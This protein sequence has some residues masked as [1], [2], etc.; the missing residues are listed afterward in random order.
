MRNLLNSKV[1][2][3]IGV[4]VI[5]VLSAGAFMNFSQN[6]TEVLDSKASGKPQ[7]VEP[8]EKPNTMTSVKDTEKRTEAEKAEKI[9]VP[10][11]EVEEVVEVE[12][13]KDNS[14]FIDAY[15]V[16]KGDTLLQIAETYNLNLTEILEL[17]PQ[18]S[19]P[20]LI[21][22]GESIAI[23]NTESMTEVKKDVA[24]EGK[25]ISIS[26]DQEKAVPKVV[27]ADKSVKEEESKPVEP[28]I[29][30]TEKKPS[31]S[32]KEI[33]TTIKKDTSETKEPTNSIEKPSDS[34]KSEAKPKAPSE[35][36]DAEEVPADI[37]PGTFE[38]P[39]E[40]SIE[41]IFN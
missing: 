8:K 6:S 29:Q 9:S 19:N 23:G 39:I 3:L 40:L 17:N 14:S 25:E 27:T 7:K 33:I 21:I 20:D 18:I 34:S 35:P 15:V 32:P 10:V 1:L 31:E 4:L 37:G 5:V 28:K 11:E 2:M 12:T 30:P 16:K 26:V 38:N 36:K 22:I 24:K 13:E 41:E